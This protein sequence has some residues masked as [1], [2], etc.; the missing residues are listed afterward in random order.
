ME[1]KPFTGLMEA[2]LF[3]GLTEADAFV[4]AS[5]ISSSDLYRER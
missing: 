2:D 4:R 3:A 1:A 5:L